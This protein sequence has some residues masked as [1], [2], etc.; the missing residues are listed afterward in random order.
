MLVPE[1]LN[2]LLYI[3][4]GVVAYLVVV[5]V[6][7]LVSPQLAGSLGAVFPYVLIAAALMAAGIAVVLVLLGRDIVA[8]PA[9][10]PTASKKRPVR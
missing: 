2:Y 9:P 4:A 10:A 3:A 7:A 8:I 1:P 5:F 6:V